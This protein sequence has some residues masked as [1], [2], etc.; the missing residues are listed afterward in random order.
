VR[1]KTFH[2]YAAEPYRAHFDL[3]LPRV[4]VPLAEAPPFPCSDAPRVRHPRE[5]KGE[6]Y[7]LT[8]AASGNGCAPGGGKRGDCC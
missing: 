6:G 2:I 3:V 8:S 4:L 7:A 5:T 1:E